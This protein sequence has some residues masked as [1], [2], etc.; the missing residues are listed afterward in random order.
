MH[1][2]CGRRRAKKALSN[3]G[4]TVVVA[5]RIGDRTSLEDCI[6]VHR[7]LRGEAKS[8]KKKVAPIRF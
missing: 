4:F 3:P 6:V 2:I 1:L 8:T 7:H 5:S